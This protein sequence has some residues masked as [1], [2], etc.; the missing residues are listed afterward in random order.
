M[1]HSRIVL[2]LILGIVL[3]AHA[4]SPVDSVISKEVTGAEKMPVIYH[5]RGTVVQADT[6]NGRLILNTSGHLDTLKVDRSVSVIR[7]TR[8]DVFG[9]LLPRENVICAYEL[10][11]GKK[12]ASGI[13]VRRTGLASPH[14][15]MRPTVPPPGVNPVKPKK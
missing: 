13:T 6:I 2:F 3:V 11:R 10:R 7:G 5:E 12:H 14:R 15:P 9:N 4:K 8:K 1:H